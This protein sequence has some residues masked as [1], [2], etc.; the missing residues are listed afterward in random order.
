[1]KFL[2]PNAKVSGSVLVDNVLYAATTDDCANVPNGV[3]TIDLGSDAKT[4][5]SWQTKANV[6]GSAGPTIGTDG[7]V[8]VAT[9][10]AQ[11]VALRGKSLAPKDSFTAAI[12]G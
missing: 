10:D 8:Y 7:T 5:A 9:T 6:I 3:W 1:V 2:A 11:I 12:F 4:I